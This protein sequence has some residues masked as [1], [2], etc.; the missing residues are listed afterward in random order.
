MS[1][2]NGKKLIWVIGPEDCHIRV[3]HRLTDC[4][5]KAGM[6]GY[7]IEFQGKD[8]CLANLKIARQFEVVLKPDLV[9][10]YLSS[11]SYGP[12]CFD[13]EEDFKDYLSRIK[14]I[15]PDMPLIVFSHV[16]RGH[17]IFIHTEES[18]DKIFDWPP[19][20][21]ELSETIQMLLEYP[22]FE[23]A[24]AKLDDGTVL[25]LFDLIKQGKKTIDVRRFTPDRQK[26]KGGKV[27]AFRSVVTREMIKRQVGTIWAVA[28]PVELLDWIEEHTSEDPLPKI[29]P[30]VSSVQE[31]EKIIYSFPGYSEDIS[32]YGLIA[33]QLK[34]ISEPRLEG[35]AVPIKLC[36]CSD[37][38]R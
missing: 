15:A 33:F 16:P 14:H 24:D 4:F 35:D 17:P 12:D 38:G 30:G 8:S 27:I 13:S 29:F 10:L 2:N 25:N 23:V 11:V 19:R 20:D 18:V 34:E 22:I 6:T 9:I 5:G 32:K 36:K 28:S 3:A 31:A 26:I 37:R 21:S 7:G 1:E